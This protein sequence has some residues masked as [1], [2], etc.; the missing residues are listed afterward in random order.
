FDGSFDIER[1]PVGRT[2]NLYAEPLVGLALP[3]D[4]SDALADLCSASATPPCQ[5]PAVNTNFNVRIQPAS[6]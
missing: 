3:A 2:Y 6:Q 5:T 1:L 4:F